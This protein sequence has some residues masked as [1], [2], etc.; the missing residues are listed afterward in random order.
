M[1]TKIGLMITAPY[2]LPKGISNRRLPPPF[3]WTNVLAFMMVL[4]R[5]SLISMNC[6]PKSKVFKKQN[7]NAEE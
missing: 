5:T 6:L 2:W 1:N 4:I 3:N 7:L